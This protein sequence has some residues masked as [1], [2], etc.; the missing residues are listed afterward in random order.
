MKIVVVTELH[1]FPPIG[2]DTIRIFNILKALSNFASVHLVILDCD[3]KS[4]KEYT[5]NCYDNLT[6]ETTYLVKN[7]TPGS[8]LL[9]RLQ[10]RK[11]ILKE[12]T[13]ISEKLK[14]D[15]VWL[16]YGYIA[17][18]HHA[19]SAAKVIFDTQNVQSE[20]DRQIVNLPN[21]NLFRKIYAN[22]IWKASKYHERKYLPACDAVI[23]VS[24]QDL[25]YYKSFI[26]LEKLWEISNF[27]DLPKYQKLPQN[28]LKKRIVFTGSMDA[29]QNQRA[30]N[31]LI[32]EVW[33][34]IVREIP[35][36]ELFIVGKNPPLRWLEISDHRIKVTGK[37][38]STISYIQGA[39]IA[40][41]PV[42]DGSGT[43]Y[44]IL[45][46]MACRTPVVSTPLG[47]QGL[48]VQD[49][50]DI[51]IAESAEGL[52]QQ[53]IELLKSPQ[54][55]ASIATKGYQLVKQKHS[56]EANINLLK[57]LCEKLLED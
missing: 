10:P 32:N 49:N 15:I 43:R 31:Y 57:Q 52:A 47:C 55:Q 5:V 18:Y 11:D 35:D 56:L 44:K 27:V 28:P 25:D 51:L 29:F 3:K 4:S 26:I 9:E 14:P 45:E 46:A 37:V 12:L 22:L 41:V 38:D 8:G 1:P 53:T 16:E 36:C 40:I 39:N 6:I 13:K 21:L 20:I 7:K 24:Q 48:D 19:F 17:H 54:K 42:L 2:G 23:T 50:V 33:P 34:K 30:G